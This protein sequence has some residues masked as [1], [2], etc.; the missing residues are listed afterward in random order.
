MLADAYRCGQRRFEAIEVGESEFPYLQDLDLSFSEFFGCWFHSATFANVNLSNA[1][2]TNCNLKC[3]TFDACNLRGVT[4]RS[5]T[6]C[7]MA[8]IRSDTT[9]TEVENLDAYG[10][11]LTSTSEFLEYVIKDDQ[12][13]SEKFWRVSAHEHLLKS[14]GV[15]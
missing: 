6:V 4:W 13:S 10:A 14:S 11:L 7:S 15:A 2:F 3:S 12:T 9:G 8:I 5:S 1:I